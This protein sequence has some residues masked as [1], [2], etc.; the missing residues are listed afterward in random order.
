[1]Y[2]ECNVLPS[3]GAITAVAEVIAQETYSILGEDSLPRGAPRTH[4]RRDSLVPLSKLPGI[5]EI[6]AILRA[7]LR[8]GRTEVHEA[9][10]KVLKGWPGRRRGELW[11]RLRQLRNETSRNGRRHAVWTE[12]DI[13][14]LRAYY[15]K[16]RAGARLAVREL[17]ARDPNKSA[18][19]ISYKARKLGISTGTGKPK[20]WMP[21]ELGDLLWNAGEK[22]VRRIARKLGRSEKAVR[23]MLSSRG[24]TARVRVPKDNNLHRVSKMLGVS[25]AAV[26]L[27]FQR[28]LFGEAVNQSKNPGR[29]QPRSRLSLEAIVAFCVKHPD[30]IDLECCDPDLLLLLEDK[31]VRLAGWHGSRQHLVQARCCPRCG[32]V[33]RGNSYFRHVKCCIATSASTRELET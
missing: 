1:M 18:G 31:K 27:W 21:E 15:A 2:L 7:V 12:E 26:R 13:E 17:L 14:I 20:P 5:N 33:I 24:A 29:S 16:G 11:A 19:S 10:E 32:R 8:A 4:P 28:G 30:K 22:P 23:Q 9:I 6:D 25:D 3:Q